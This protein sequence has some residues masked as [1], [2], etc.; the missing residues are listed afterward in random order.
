MLGLH[1]SFWHL[2]C[3]SFTVLFPPGLSNFRQPLLSLFSFTCWVHSGASS[4]CAELT[5]Q[6][7]FPQGVTGLFWLVDLRRNKGQAKNFASLRPPTPSPLMCLLAFIWPQI[8]TPL[9]FPYVP[10]SFWPSVWTHLELQKFSKVES[11][12]GFP[13][14]TSPSLPPDPCLIEIWPILLFL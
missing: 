10:R 14:P 11:G 2:L 12:R 1:L 5:I 3:F 6:V 13:I 7:L 8:P 9:P 4:S